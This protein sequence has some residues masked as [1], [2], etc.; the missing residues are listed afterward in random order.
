V[1]LAAVAI[2]AALGAG[3]G[4]CVGYFQAR[5]MRLAAWLPAGAV[6]VAYPVLWTLLDSQAKDLMEWATWGFAPTAL[7]AAWLLGRRQTRRRRI[8]AES[9]AQTK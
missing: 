5:R 2:G 7:L 1:R 9:S 6:A 3:L 4:A 8:A